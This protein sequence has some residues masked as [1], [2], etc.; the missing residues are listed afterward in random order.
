[1]NLSNNRKGNNI[2]NNLTYVLFVIYLIALFWIILFKFNVPVNHGRIV[3]SINLIPFSDPVILNSKVDFG[4][5]ILNVI[6][7]VPLGI[8]A[9]ILFKRWS[10]GKKLLLFFLISLVCEVFQFILGIGSSDI[11]DIITNTLGGIIGL[12]IFRGVEKA[13]K[14][15]AKAQKLINIIATTGTILM[16]LLLLLLKI[17]HLWI[18][19]MDT[20]HTTPE[21]K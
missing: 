14:N 13:F 5:P 7:F 21:A 3:R 11:T 1:M 6:V 12:L 18:F 2:T 17:K 9:G 15:S 20:L 19:R 4:E 10:A 16:I 8:Y